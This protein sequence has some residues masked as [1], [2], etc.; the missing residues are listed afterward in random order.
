MLDA[1]I[2]IGRPSLMADLRAEHGVACLYTAVLTRPQHLHTAALV[3]A[4]SG[5]QVPAWRDQHEP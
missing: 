4:A 1:S 3:D 2:R 5:L